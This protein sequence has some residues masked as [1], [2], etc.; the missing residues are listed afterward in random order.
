M[1]WEVRGGEKYQL[2]LKAKKEDEV[3]STQLT[4]KV[5]VHFIVVIIWFYLFISI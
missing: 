3:L 5:V 4:E 2:L 1:D